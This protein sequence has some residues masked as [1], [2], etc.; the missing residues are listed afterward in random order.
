[1]DGRRNQLRNDTEVKHKST[2]K[3]TDTF[4]FIEKFY[5]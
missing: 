5:E 2:L 3:T 4:L 1:M